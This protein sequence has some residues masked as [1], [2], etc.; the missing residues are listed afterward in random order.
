MTEKK[1]LGILAIV[2]GGVG[3]AFSW[4]PFIN[5]MAFILGIVGV[6]LG[7]IAIITNL[8]SKKTLALIGTVISILSLIIVLTTQ[9]LYSNQ[10]NKAFSGDSTPNSQKESS[11][12]ATNKSVS[13]SN[14]P[15]KNT[16]TFKHDVFS[17]GIMTYK[18]TKSEVRDSIENGKK[19]LVIY[20]DVTN[21]TDSEQDPSNIYT[22]MHAFQKTDTANKNLIPGMVK[23]DENSNNPIQQYTDALND[24]LLG[25]KTTSVAL[26][27]S[28]ENNNPVTVKF[29]NADFT[30]IGEKQYDVK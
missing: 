25:K 14:D 28:L 8:K 21:N 15:S 4:V 6:V 1:I 7:V 29:D 24:K 26:V 30:K 16:W 12:K 27:Y 20:A 11:E 18:F 3:L 9:N 22:V 2:F 23:Y 5:N 17:A 13:N 10:L 19:T